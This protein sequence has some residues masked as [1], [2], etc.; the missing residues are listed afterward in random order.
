MTH[1]VWLALKQTEAQ[2]AAVALAQEGFFFN[3][4]DDGYT[5]VHRTDDG[6]LRTLQN[7]AFGLIST[8]PVGSFWELLR[9]S[10]SSSSSGSDF[11]LRTNWDEGLGA[12]ALSTGW[13][14]SPKVLDPTFTFA[15]PAK[16]VAF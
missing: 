6:C 3:G 7:R 5:D 10:N 15:V 1:P 12:D 13:E 2:L 14:V 4:F 11:F 16:M 9:K 8:F